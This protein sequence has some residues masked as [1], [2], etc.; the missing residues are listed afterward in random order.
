MTQ[1]YAVAPP[2]PGSLGTDVPA[3][4]L[5]RYLD[6]MLR[7]RDQR[8]SE[9][10]ALD[11][12]AMEL[13]DPQERISVTPDVTLSMTLWQAV[14]DRLELLLAT[15]D[16]GRV[17]EHERR[18]I[19]TL[20]WGTLEQPGS[21]AGA[22]ALA[23]SLPEACR[24]SDSLA[25]SLRSRLR[26]DGSDPRTTERLTA[27]RAQVARIADQVALIPTSRRGSAQEVHDRLVQRVEDL[28]ERARRGGDVGG[29]LGP[30]EAD[31]ATA[32]RDLIVAAS[33]RAHAKADH[34]QATRE[35]AEM[36][37]RGDAVR[38]L[39]RRARELVTPAPTLG[40]PDV[41]A[42]GP[43]PSEPAELTSYLSKLERVDK[44]LGIAQTA[45][46]QALAR[47]EEL[48]QRAGAVRAALAGDA[49]ATAAM[50]GL[51]E[52]AAALIE[53]RPTDLTRLEA[54][55]QAQETFARTMGVHL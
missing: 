11:R 39:A 8:R 3:P 21:R 15:W 48:A 44:A 14:A 30:L 17:G 35:V 19:T 27:L 45:Y 5:L 50:G 9:L 29:F 46:A 12:A 49:D 16:D 34:A 52:Q 55:V 47:R 26:L 36:K 40:V 2:A 43:V 28:T 31:A 33:A 10:E 54:L 4:E 38:A 7:W 23:V 42:L 18:R 1:T 53:S 41:T 20:V 25:T 6:A 32:E 51:A 13:P 24:L 37:A 22:Q